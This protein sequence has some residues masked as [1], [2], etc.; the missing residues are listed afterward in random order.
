MKKIIRQLKLLM[1]STVIILII[2]VNAFLIQPNLLRVR[3]ET[4]C[5]EKI[6]ESMN[7]YTIVFFSD[8]HYNKFTTKT[9]TEKLVNTINSIGAQ[10]VVFL[11]DLYN[12]PASN[13]VDQETQ[14][15]LAELLNSIEAEYGKFA[16]MGNHDYES[17]DASILTMQ[18]LAYGNFELLVNQSQKIY[19]GNEGFVE[20]I[21]IDCLTLGNPDITRAYKGI[22]S[23][24]FNIVISHCPDT[25]DTIDYSLSDLFLAGH[26][27]GGQIFIPVIETFFR[28]LGA[29]KYFTGKHSFPNQPLLDITNG[30]GTTIINAR[31]NAPA[32]I[33]VYRLIH[34]E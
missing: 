26:S 9:R 5:S 15:E 31:F 10:T 13:E 24:S 22:S 11:G 16:I 20:L 1:L 34:E 19:F 14:I 33:V 30:V 25:Y 7:N 4:I 6:P 17:N 18:T 3:Y 28:T 12:H 2:L 27:H 23:E 8:L 29:T 21:A 32:E